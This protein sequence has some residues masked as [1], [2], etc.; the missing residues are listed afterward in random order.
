MGFQVGVGYLLV[1]FDWDRE[2]RAAFAQEFLQ[3]LGGFA[4]GRGFV[5]GA[6]DDQRAV[7][8]AGEGG[9]RKRREVGQRAAGG[10]FDVGLELGGGDALACVVAA[11]RVHGFVEGRVAQDAAEGVQ[12]QDALAGGDAV[13][14]V[15]GHVGLDVGEGDVAAG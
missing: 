14:V 15:L 2:V 12:E 9:D 7:H 1:G 13:P 4:V 8:V 10:F 11:E 6:V 3:G 5:R